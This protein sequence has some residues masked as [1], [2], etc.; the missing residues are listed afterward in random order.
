[1]LENEKTEERKKLEKLL[2]EVLSDPDSEFGKKLLEDIKKLR[3]RKTSTT[4]L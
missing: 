1:M 4:S 2:R 3:E